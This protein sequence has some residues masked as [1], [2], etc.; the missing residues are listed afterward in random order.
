MDEHRQPTKFYGYKD[1]YK[2]A[3]E[4]SHVPNYAIMIYDVSKLVP[5]N[6]LFF[7]EQKKN[8]RF[9]L[10]PIENHVK[11]E[12]VKTTGGGDKN[13]GGQQTQEVPQGPKIDL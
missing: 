2:S 1:R 10:V 6:S 8:K 11:F 3:D 9:R 7:I 5:E 4:R 12:K 13:K